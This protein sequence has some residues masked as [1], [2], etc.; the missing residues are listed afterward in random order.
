MKL[1]PS[2]VIL[3][4]SYTTRRLYYTQVILHASYTTRRLYYTRV[5][6]HAGY[7]TRELYYTRVILHAG[8]NDLQS[9]NT[10]V[11]SANG[12]IILGNTLKTE[13]NDVIISGIIPRWG[14][15][16]RRL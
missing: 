13:N 11:E 16:R 15:R 8:T 1:N 10:A 6:L 2:R 4:A 12:L 7:T 5:I 14:M 3:H 9:G